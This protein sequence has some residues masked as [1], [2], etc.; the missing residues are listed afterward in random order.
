MKRELLT[1][2]QTDIAIAIREVVKTPDSEAWACFTDFTRAVA[3][4]LEGAEGLIH[5]TEMQQRFARAWEA[6]APKLWSTEHNRIVRDC[7]GSQEEFDRVK[8]HPNGRAA[9]VRILSRV[10]EIHGDLTPG[11]SIDVDVGDILIDELGET[12]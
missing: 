2:R 3:T 12:T 7:L 5:T 9:I 10:K 4:M 1:D 11:M 6:Y 8:A